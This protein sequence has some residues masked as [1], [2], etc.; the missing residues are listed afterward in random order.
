MSKKEVRKLFG[1]PDCK[2]VYN[3]ATA[4]VIRAR[5]FG[6]DEAALK[7]DIEAIFGEPVLW[8]YGR[9]SIDEASKEAYVV[10]FDAGGH[11]IRWRRPIDG[12]LADTSEPVEPEF[13]GDEPIAPSQSPSELWKTPVMQPR[14][15][16]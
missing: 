3:N 14:R 12:P 10:Y 6:D 1:S 15:Q 4:H 7:A 16:K 8:Q 2:I 11:V 9:F 13:G 5:E